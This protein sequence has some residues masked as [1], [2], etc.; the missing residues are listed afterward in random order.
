MLSEKHC[1]QTAASD[2]QAE[3][4][5]NVYQEFIHCH[6]SNAANIVDNIMTLTSAT[7]ALMAASSVA[8]L[9]TNDNVNCCFSTSAEALEPLA[10]SQAKCPKQ[11]V[12]YL[13]IVGLDA[14]DN[15]ACGNSVPS[16]CQ[17]SGRDQP[18]MSIFT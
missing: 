14:D 13:E 5:R 16:S 2:C 11:A 15:G 8:S 4:H 9:S 17:A 7:K 6:N 12:E 3:H 10:N 1:N 18:I